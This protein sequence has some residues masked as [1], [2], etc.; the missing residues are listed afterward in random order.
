MK[1]TL[2]MPDSSGRRVNPLVLIALAGIF[3]GWF[4]LDTLVIRIGPM[5]HTLKFYEMF[6]AIL[7]PPRV[8]MGLDSGHV[9]SSI[10]FGLVCA[11]VLLACH[12]HSLPPRCLRPMLVC[13]PLLLM[14]LIALL[15]F[16][17]L[18]GDLFTDPGRGAPIVSDLVRL[19]N[20]VFNRGAAAITRANAGV[21]LWVSAAACVLLA[22]QGYREKS[23]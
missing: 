1:N 5:R 18:P 20:N 4:V 9:F 23:R 2:S 14:L 11:T 21:G 7:D 12:V 3:L 13:A 16:M 6:A 10:A 15:L 8:L 19:A 17:R 22:W